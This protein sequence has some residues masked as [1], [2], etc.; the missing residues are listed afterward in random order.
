MPASGWLFVPGFQTCGLPGAG[1]VPVFFR[2]D[3]LIKWVF[4]LRCK[5]HIPIYRKKCLHRRIGDHSIF[6][7]LKPGAIDFTPS[8]LIFFQWLGVGKTTK[9]QK[10]THAG[11]RPKRGPVPPNAGAAACGNGIRP[12]IPP[13]GLAYFGRNSGLITGRAGPSFG[14]AFLPLFWR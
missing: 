1:R 12:G 5:K 9:K 14:L 2:K 3:S 8:G 13:K 6:P 10:K 4:A 7:G 11:R